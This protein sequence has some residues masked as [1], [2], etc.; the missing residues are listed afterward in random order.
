[1]NDVLF[2]NKTMHALVR[3]LDDVK[4][5]PAKENDDCGQQYWLHF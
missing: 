1:M 2:D 4:C 5:S 3:I